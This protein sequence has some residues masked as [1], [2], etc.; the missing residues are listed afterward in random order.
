MRKRRKHRQPIPQFSIRT[1][2]GLTTATAL[3]LGVLRWLNVPAR[4]SWLVLVV[5][6]AGG[7]AA[8]ALVAVIAGQDSGEDDRD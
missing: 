5:M 4:A 2:L 6:A 1:L 3:L 8:V 7:V